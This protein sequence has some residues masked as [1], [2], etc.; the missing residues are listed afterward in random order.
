MIPRFGESSEPRLGF[1]TCGRRALGKLPRRAL[2][3]VR[4]RVGERD[5][6]M[7][8]QRPHQVLV[9]L[10][11]G[12]ALWSV[13]RQDELSKRPRMDAQR[14][15]HEAVQPDGAGVLV[16]VRVRVLANLVEVEC[17]SDERLTTLMDALRQRIPIQR[18]RAGEQLACSLLGLR[19]EPSHHRGDEL[20]PI[21]RQ[22]Q[23]DTLVGD[24]L[25]QPPR[26]RIEEV[27]GVLRGRREIAGRIGQDPQTFRQLLRSTCPRR[28]V[29]Q[30]HI[31]RDREPSRHVV[32]L[33]VI[34]DGHASVGL[35]E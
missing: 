10:V 17:G 9:V 3:G 34:R 8:G 32:D 28:E 11:E 31:E 35:P 14:H 30:Q 16:S 20:A 21:L 24:D 12:R 33:W 6:G 13:A 26:D 19:I 2:G 7:V 25:G 18:K 4:M 15:H 29:V 1:S 27:V 5:R 22:Q 23:H